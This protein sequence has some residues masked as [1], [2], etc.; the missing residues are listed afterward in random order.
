M[1]F[2]GLQTYFIFFFYFYFFFLLQ[3]SCMSETWIET[4]LQRGEM[5]SFSHPKTRKDFRLQNE[6]VLILYLKK[7]I[8]PIFFV[9]ENYVILCIKK[10]FMSFIPNSYELFFLV[11]KFLRASN[12]TLCIFSLMKRSPFLVTKKKRNGILINIV[13]A[14]FFVW[15]F[16]PNN[17]IL[18]PRSTR[19]QIWSKLNQNKWRFT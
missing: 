11:K 9:V 19:P 18:L 14:F 16:F 4:R 6:C 15:P 3:E 13:V 12:T 1:I 8:L 2:Y 5:D 7:I 10:K 17:M